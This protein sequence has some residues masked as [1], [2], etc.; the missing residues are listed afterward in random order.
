MEMLVLKKFCCILLNTFI[1]NF[2]AVMSFVVTSMESY[3]YLLFF[4]QTAPY[5]TLKYWVSRDR[6]PEDHH[7]CLFCL[8]MNLQEGLGGWDGGKWENESGGDA[9]SFTLLGTHLIIAQGTE[10]GAPRRLP[11]GTPPPTHW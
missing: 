1:N 8:R 3:I 11:G 4:L 2:E 5:K 10:T 6:N 7:F 9:S